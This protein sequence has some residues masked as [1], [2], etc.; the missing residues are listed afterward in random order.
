MGTWVAVII[1]LLFGLGRLFWDKLQ[2][3]ETSGNHDAI[4]ANRLQKVIIPDSVPNQTVEY[5][6]YLCY[7]NPKLHI[8]NC[9][10][11]ELTADEI[12]GNVPRVNNFKCDNNVEGCP[13]PTWYTGSG[14]D[15]GHMAPAADFHWSEQ[16]M[17]ES[18]LMTN[19]CPQDHYVNSHAWNSLE[20]KVRNWAARDSS[21]IIV[22]GP[23]LSKNMPTL[24]KGVAVPQ[25][26]FKVILAHKA[27]PMRAIAFIM[28]NKK[29]DS[30]LVSYA[31]T[32]DE[33]ESRSGL[34]FFS[35]LPDDIENDIESQFSY[36][37][38]NK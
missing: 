7:F 8:P 21:L 19:V 17:R 5:M 18:F 3:A 36:Q 37:R 6:A 24:K 30:N 20:Q 29:C 9:V 34:D 10:A 22:T 35:D 25:H 11:Y 28:P 1:V 38:W 13:D 16:A 12:D 4:A 2:A 14:Y 33:V 15:R 31:V 26:F 32:V 23:I 27:S